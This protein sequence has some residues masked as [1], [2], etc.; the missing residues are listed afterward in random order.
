MKIHIV[1]DTQGTIRSLAVPGPD[2][3]DGFGVAPKHDEQVSVVD[4]PDL[5]AQQMSQHL[6]D[7][8]ER[9]RVD[10]SS[11]KPRLVQK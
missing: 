2:F 7:M 10:V 11:G 1:H 8:Y 3:V 5:D 9:F 6:R 4:G